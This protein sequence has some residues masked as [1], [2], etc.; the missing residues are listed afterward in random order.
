MCVCV[1]AWVRCQRR[2]NVSFVT[3][4]CAYAPTAKAL[5]AV[6]SQFLEQLQDTL[7][8]VPLGDTLVMLGDFNARVGMFD[9]ADGLWHKTI[10]RYGLAA[11]NRAGELLQFCELNQLTVL[12]TCFQKSIHL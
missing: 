6:R 11:R 1:C 3:I 10:D 7:A 8:D 9:P 12:N 4:V 2:S 5:P